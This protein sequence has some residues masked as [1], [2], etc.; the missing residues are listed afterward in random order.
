MPAYPGRPSP[1]SSTG[2]ATVDPQLRAIVQQAIDATGY[3][4]EPGRPVPG[5]PKDRFGGAG[6]SPNPAAATF[7]QPFLSRIFTDPYL[8]RHHRRCA[9]GPA[10]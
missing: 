10:P 7:D 6:R 4:T 2:F 1:V 9:A 5:D 8:G 3:V